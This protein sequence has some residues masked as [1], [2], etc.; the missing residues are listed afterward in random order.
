MPDQTNYED[1]RHSK[2]VD[3]TVSVDVA[4]ED[5]FFTGFVKNISNGG[6][7]IATDNLPP[8][9]TSFNVKFTVPTLPDYVTVTVVV[10]WIRRSRPDDTDVVQGIG[11]RFVDLD[12]K[13]AAAIDA[14]IKHHDTL[15]YE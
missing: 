13:V 14:F 15:F 7:F 9:G 12:P 1:Q 8:V 6:L 4:T 5:N 11:V 3:Y 10:R 2:R